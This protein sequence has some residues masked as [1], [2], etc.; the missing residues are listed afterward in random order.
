MAINDCPTYPVVWTE[1]DRLP[2]IDGTLEGVDITGYT[3]TMRLQRPDT[4]APIVLTKTATIVDAAAGQ[5]R[6]SWLSTDLV[7]GQNQLTV[8]QIANASGLPLT[9]QRFLIDVLELPA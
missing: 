8:I 6:F 1:G 9:P 7:A 4:A 5:F 3:I 2:E